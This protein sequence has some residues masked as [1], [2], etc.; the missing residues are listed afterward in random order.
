MTKGIKK[1]K[2]LRPTNTRA[3]LVN[4]NNIYEKVSLLDQPVHLPIQ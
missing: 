1:V 3:I 2:Y 4:E